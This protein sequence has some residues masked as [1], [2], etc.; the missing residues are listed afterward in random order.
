MTE[1][2]RITAALQGRWHGRYGL[3]RCPAHGDKNP[4]LTLADGPSGRLLA[5]CKTGCAFADVLDA[6]R[7][8][9]IVEGRGQVPETD[10]AEL[11]RYQAAQRQEAERKERQALAVWREALPVHGTIAEPY[12]RGRGITCDLPDTLRFHPQCWHGATARRL[13]ALVAR[14]DG[15]ERFAVHRTYLRGDGRGKAEVDPAK[16]MLGPTLGG[17]VRLTEGA[18]PLVVA[19]GIETALSLASGLLRGPA[20]IWAALSASGLAGLRLPDLPGRLTVAT[21][22]DAAGKVAGNKLAE[23]AAALGWAVSLLPAPDGRD[24]ND[25]LFQDDGKPKGM[26]EGGAA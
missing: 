14:V 6:L 9:G 15:A 7:G 3:A 25:V 11:A 26:T 22:G 16:A 1:A 13:P 10:P 19:E 23:R 8:L 5:H 18:G 4:S 17:A 2:Q 12:L 24:W 20:P 21:D